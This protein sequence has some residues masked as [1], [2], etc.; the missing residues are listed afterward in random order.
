MVDPLSHQ[1]GGREKAASCT[2]R[3]QGTTTV[4]AGVTGDNTGGIRG[5]AAHCG[6]KR[7]NAQGVQD[8]C[9]VTAQFDSAVFENSTV[10]HDRFSSILESERYLR[11][12]RKSRD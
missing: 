9:H 11:R 2:A 3:W 6:W 4:Y 5:H 1:L 10:C 7:P 8:F 12:L